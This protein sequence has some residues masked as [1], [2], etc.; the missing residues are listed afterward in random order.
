MALQDARD[1]VDGA[2]TRDDAK[3]LNFENAF[4]GATSIFRRRYTKDLTGFDL[5]VTGVPFDQAVT[6]R[7]GSRF[8]P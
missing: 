4:G 3:G 8:G 5:A 6:H 7:P 2:I 1:Q